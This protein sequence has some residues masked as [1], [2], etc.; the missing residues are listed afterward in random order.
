MAQAGSPALPVTDDAIEEV[1]VTARQLPPQPDVADPIAVRGAEDIA[2][3]QAQDIFAVTRDIP[4]VSMNGGPRASGMKFNI[5]GFSDTEDVIVELDG[6]ARGFEKYRFGSGVFVEPEL[7]ERLEV[8][9][10]P[11]ISRG[12]GALGGSV[13]ARTRDADDLLAAGETLGLFLKSGYST[14]DDGR[15]VSASLYGLPA[16]HLGLLAS[17]TLRNGNDMRLPDGTRLADSDTDSRSWL[18]KARWELGDA[19][20]LRAGYIGWADSGQQPYDATGGQPGFFGTV[21]RDI[22]DRTAF[23][24]LRHATGDGWIDVTAVAGRVDT[25]LEDL[26]RPGE[27]PLANAVTGNITDTY[28]YRTNVLRLDNIS[29]LQ[30]GNVDVM[31]LSGAQFLDATRDISRVTGNEAIN[32]ALYPEGYNAAQPPGARRS[33]GV[34]LQPAV[35]AGRVTLRAG[36]RWDRYVTEAHGG[37]AERMAAAGQATRIEVNQLTPALGAEL[38]VVSDLLRV[39]YSYTGAFRPPL[40]DEYFT[41]GA[42]SRCTPVFLGGAAPASGICGDLYNPEESRNREVGMALSASAPAGGVMSLRVAY[43]RS[44]VRHTL[45]SITVVSPGEIGQPGRESRDGIEAELDLDT[46]YGF[47]R[48]SWSEAAGTRSG[49][50]QPGDLFDLPG[51]R[52]VLTLGARALDRRVE[53]GYRLEDTHARDAVV[54][55]VGV[56]PVIGTQEGYRLHAAFASWRALDWLEFRLAGENLTSTSYRLNDG[57]GGAPGT[58]APGRNL[59]LALIAQF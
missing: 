12:S 51:D 15:L 37:T 21:L 5:R 38:V 27:T 26:L 49:G 39:F 59:R 56:Q 43:F 3:L 50:T 6:I 45:E 31:L 46:D 28:D 16:E 8:E 14:N 54:G 47:V 2:R 22:D 53:V 23:I 9:R 19:T 17:A 25:R 58:Q 10:S 1:V 7:I 29:R 48:L 55:T 13:S 20:A 41:Q 40:V 44:E 42:F 24:E 11:S 4:G 18:L 33:V 30:A 34:Y 36:G 35:T 32:Q 57:F 52:F